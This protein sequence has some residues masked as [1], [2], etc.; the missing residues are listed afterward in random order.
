MEHDQSLILY[1]Y[2]L[3]FQRPEEYF[4]EQIDSLQAELN[5][6]SAQLEKLEAK[7]HQSKELEVCFKEL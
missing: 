4:S 7:S 3:Y 5:E 6:K 2:Y 1:K